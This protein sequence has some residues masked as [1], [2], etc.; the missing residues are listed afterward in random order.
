MGVLITYNALFVMLLL[1]FYSNDLV[2]T[3]FCDSND[4]TKIGSHFFLLFLITRY[5]L[6]KKK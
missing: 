3:I 1:L 2:M 6:K 4:N 5:S